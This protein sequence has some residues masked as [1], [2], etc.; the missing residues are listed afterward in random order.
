MSAIATPSDRQRYVLDSFAIISQ[1]Q[2]E[3]GA[4]KV[5]QVLQQGRDE[6]AEVFLSVVNFGEALYIIE[7]DHGLN[8]ANQASAAI[9]EWPVRLVDV[10]RVLAVS[11]AHFK[12]RFAISFADGFALALAQS[13]GACVLTGDPEFRQTERIVPVEW[14]PR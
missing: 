13:L 5:D 4:D 7:R 14:L 3:A 11:A 9:N 2:A 10:D 6:H 12:A 1:L 8:A